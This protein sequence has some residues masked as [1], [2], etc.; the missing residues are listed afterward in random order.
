MSY[1]NLYQYKKQEE[2]KIQ[3]YKMS[4]T[5]VEKTAQNQEEWKI[6][7]PKLNLAGNIKEGTQ[8]EVLVDYVGHF[9]QTPQWEGNIGLIANNSGGN[10]NYFENLENLVEKDVIIYQ[11]Q[12]KQ[13]EYEVTQNIII[14][15]TDW[16]YLSSTEQNQLTLI[17]GAKTQENQRRCVQAVQIIK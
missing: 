9:T 5:N 4:Q 2:S 14:Q 3:E 17:T 10:V 7:I 11:Y 13:R 15:D 12:G 1:A 16:S 6:V 8:Q